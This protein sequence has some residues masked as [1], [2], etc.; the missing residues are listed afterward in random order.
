MKIIKQKISGRLEVLPD[1]VVVWLAADAAAAK[2]TVSPTPEIYLSY[3][4]VTMGPEEHVFPSFLLDDWGNEIKSLEL[5]H[6]IR[7]YGEQFPRAELFGY[8]L[9]GESRQHFLRELELYAPYPCYA[10]AATNGP[11][12]D[13]RVVTD[14]CMT[15]LLASFPQQI[16]AP[17]EIAYPLRGA[18]VRWWSVP[19][20]TQQLD[21]L[22]TVERSKSNGW[23]E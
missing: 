1:Q 16:A 14:L 18:A 3:A 7:E 4:L 9:N 19:P 22:E 17:Q 23:A 2:A 8:G 13:A 21:F 12:A 15:D 6:W 20:G 11:L 5:Y 10:F